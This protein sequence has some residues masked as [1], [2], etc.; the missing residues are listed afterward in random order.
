[1]KFQFLSLFL[2]LVIPAQGQNSLTS[3]IDRMATSLVRQLSAKKIKTVAVADFTYQGQLNTRI[4]VDIADKI[5][6]SLTKKGLELQ[7]ISRAKTRQEL[8]SME[9]PAKPKFNF[10]T[11]VN[12]A[13]GLLKDGKNANDQAVLDHG[14]NAANAVINQM[15]KSDGKKLKGVDVIIYGTIE[16]AGD[17]L[18]INIEGTKNDTKGVNVAVEDGSIIITPEVSGKLEGTVA[19]PQPNGSP[20]NS[21]TEISPASP[22]GIRTKNQNLS[23][24]VIRCHQ[25][26]NDV[27]CKL[28]VLSSNMD[29]QISIAVGTTK[30]VDANG[31]NEFVATEVSLSD[32]SG[33]QGW[34]SKDLISNY[35]IEATLIFSNVNKQILSIA[36]LE[37]KMWSQKVS[38]FDTKLY[39]ISTQ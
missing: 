3:E 4:G 23:F 8:S 29:D 26:G 22:T 12:P 31:G 27:E 15:P 30:I 25:S 14:A 37:I 20:A 34:V 13:V 17:Y 11:L 38:Y 28:N 32:K 39:N 36:R 24:E 6:N 16:D 35:P 5:S 1:M 18:Q 21:S 19:S 10:G 7:V 33:T 9:V 2:F